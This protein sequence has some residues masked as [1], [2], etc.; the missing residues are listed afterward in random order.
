LGFTLVELLVATFIVTTI[1]AAAYHVFQTCLETWR[2]GD[3]EREAM[4]SARLFCAQLGQELT[5]GAVFQ[6][7]DGQFLGEPGR[8]V[9]TS[10]AP[11]R[12]SGASPQPCLRVRYQLRRQHGEGAA[13][14][15]ERSQ[16]LAAGGAVLSDHEGHEVVL[17]GVREFSLSYLAADSAE[18]CDTWEKRDELPVAVRL[19]V[20]LEGLAGRDPLTFR[21]VFSIPAGARQAAS[22]SPG[23]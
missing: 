12:T 13:G 21:T 18:W 17:A 7:S 1:L 16:A 3:A 9:F 8:V 15:V 19:R 4:T 6:G 14:S 11:S 22:E 23:D 10:L 20:V 5:G 2:R